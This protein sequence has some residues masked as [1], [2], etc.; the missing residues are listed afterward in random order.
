MRFRKLIAL[1]LVVLMLSGC[2]RFEKKPVGEQAYIYGL[3]VCGETVWHLAYVDGSR[4]LLRDGELMLQLGGMAQI[5]QLGHAC[6]YLSGS[7]LIRYDLTNGTERALTASSGTPSIITEDYLVV[8]DRRIAIADGSETGLKGLPEKKRVLAVDGNR[9]C[10]AD[11]SRSILGIY[12]LETDSF[13]E[14]WKYEATGNHPMTGAL[15]DGTLYFAWS[16]GGLWKLDLT[17]AG[18]EPEILTFKTPVAMAVWEDGLLCAV[19]T[20]GNQLA[21]YTGLERREPQELA[22]WTEAKYYLPDSCMLASSG[23]KAA[24][25]VSTGREII[26]FDLP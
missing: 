13:A 21:F 20:D 7:N 25:A 10:L 17:T 3:A 8:K 5:D 16:T 12:D 11:T 18:A 26:S 24:C 9:V 19:K 14:L 4:M 2:Q 23:P 1:A 15:L 6:W 22:R